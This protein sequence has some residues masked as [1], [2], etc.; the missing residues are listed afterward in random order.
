[1][2]Q[3]TACSNNNGSTYFSKKPR[4]R[5]RYASCPPHPRQ[6]NSSKNRL[7]EGLATGVTEY[8][9]G[10]KYSKPVQ[11]AKLRTN[12]ADKNAASAHR[13]PQ[14]TPALVRL[15][16]GVLRCAVAATLNRQ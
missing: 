11:D 13:Y 16:F 3:R 4:G 7:P 14:D 15:L 10:H 9:P 12:V 1:C 5:E 8:T 2:S 6:W